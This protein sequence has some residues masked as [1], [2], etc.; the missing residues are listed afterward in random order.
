MDIDT[1]SSAET[2]LVKVISKKSDPDCS[3]FTD[4]RVAEYQQLKSLK[5]KKKFVDLPCS[6]NAI[7]QN[8]KRAYFQTKMWLEA[9]FGNAAGIMDPDEF[10]Y[11]VSMSSNS[12][13]PLLF[14]GPSR[15]IDV[16]DPCSNCK[17]CVKRTCPCRQSALP[18]NDYCSCS[19][20]DCKNP[21]SG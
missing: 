8:I 14:E 17:T 2:F 7:Q 5:A 13:K 16:P 10:G 18:C 20:N 21:F 4:L 9:P 11:I 19:T 1:I 3:T 6:S 12:I 15:P